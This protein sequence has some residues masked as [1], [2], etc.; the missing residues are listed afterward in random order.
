MAEEVKREALVNQV[1]ALSPTVDNLRLML[2]E[3]RHAFNRHD[4]K[5]LDEMARLKD[6]IIFGLDPIF[7]Q[8]ET[9]LEKGPAAEKPELQKLQGVLT[10]LERMADKVADL[11]GPIRRKG[12]KGTILSDRDFFHVNDLFSQQTGLMRALVDVLHHNDPSLK[13][14]LRQEAEKLRESCFL[15]EVEHE[16]RMTLSLGQPE[17]WSIYLDILAHYREILGNLIEL[18]KILG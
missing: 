13:A 3:A 8:V 16:S 9:G 18:L 17:A 10:Q 2:G 12:N 15:D 6:E 5:K 14:Y 7:E 1:R 11:A 4:L